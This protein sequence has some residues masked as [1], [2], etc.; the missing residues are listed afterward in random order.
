MSSTR[1]SG[2]FSGKIPMTRLLPL[3]A[4]AAS[5]RTCAA[6]ST[7]G[8]GRSEFAS[9]ADETVPEAIPLGE[10]ALMALMVKTGSLAV[11]S[12]PPGAPSELRRLGDTTIRNCAPRWLSA[13]GTLFRL[14][15]LT[16]AGTGV[17]GIGGVDGDEGCS[18]GAAPEPVEGGFEPGLA[19]PES[20][21]T[22]AGG[23]EPP[24]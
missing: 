22:L 15:L 8:T 17:G 4:G 14:A 7:R 24:D 18:G 23:G 20:P 2:M 12:V 6:T 10:K 5:T 1:G 21:D 16:G 9:A 13:T 11:M 19:P 3:V